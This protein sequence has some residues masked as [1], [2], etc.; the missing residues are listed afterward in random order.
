MVQA[1]AGD[2][3][4]GIGE[5]DGILRIETDVAGL[6]GIEHRRQAGIGH[7]GAVVRRADLGVGRCGQATG[8]AVVALG[9][10]VRQVDTGDQAVLLAEGLELVAVVALELGQVAVAD[11]GL[12]AARQH[13]VGAQGV[14]RHGHSARLLRRRREADR[15]GQQVALIAA[16]AQGGLE[17]GVLAEAVQ[18]AQGG[19]AAFGLEV[20]AGQSVVVLGRQGRLDLAVGREPG[21]VVERLTVGFEVVQADRELVTRADGPAIA[22]SD[23]LL[24]DAGAVVVGLVRHRVDAQRR[25]LAGLEVEVA[26]HAQFIAAAD[27]DIDLVLVHQIGLL[28]D[29]VHHATGR[30]L[31]EQHRGR[32]L[33]HFDA[34]VVEGVALDQRRVAQAVDVD[35]AG[36]A[37]REAAQAH[38]L[39]AGFAGH[40]GHA[41]GGLEHFTEIVEVAVI[42]QPLGH[43]RDALRNVAQFLLALGGRGRGGAQAVLGLELDRIALLL[44]GHGRQRGLA[45]GR[46][47]LR[48]GIHRAGEQQRAERQQQAGSGGGLD[49]SAGRLGGLETEGQIGADVASH[50]AESLEGLLAGWQRRDALWL[51]GWRD[52]DI[53][54]ESIS[55]A[56][57]N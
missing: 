56:S 55:F 24:V 8:V 19:V 35:V 38:V 43:H 14:G 52:Y 50:V 17:L 31:A 9:V 26:S 1:Q 39:L 22:G 18:V 36:L 3:L 46:N 53:K 16:V 11:P 32:S 12:G 23:A 49:F 15:A 45:G 10:L 28:A 47:R 30:A 13:A 40:E 6:E 5:A 21:V 7:A 37:E 33:Q 25:V 34:A 29:L 42:H 57:Q 54:R 41:C 4:D 2:Q 27:G 48:A 51:A 44:D 20:V